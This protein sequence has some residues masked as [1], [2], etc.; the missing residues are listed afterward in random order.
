MEHGA[1]NWKK[2]ATKLGPTRTD[3]QCFHGWNKVIKPGLQKGAWSVE[4]D[5]LV[6]EAV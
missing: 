4:E 3:V 1:E 2:V 5:K 6:R